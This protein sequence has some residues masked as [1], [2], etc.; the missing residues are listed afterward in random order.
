[1]IKKE[2]EKTKRIIKT[3]FINHPDDINT[4]SFT[5]QNLLAWYLY[6]GWM[7]DWKM[8]SDNKNIVFQGTKEGILFNKKRNELLETIEN[9]YTKQQ[10]N[11]GMPTSESIAMCI[12]KAIITYMKIIHCK[13]KLRK[14]ELQTQLEFVLNC[15]DK[16]YTD[17]L[18]GKRKIIVFSHVKEYMK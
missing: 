14:K 6:K 7:C 18:T 8:N 9:Y 4:I 16:L 2:F 1:M 12:D 3:W 10:K 13:E 11:K 5:Y 17:I 15:A